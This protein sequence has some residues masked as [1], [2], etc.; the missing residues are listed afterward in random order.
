MA[1][2]RMNMPRAG[3]EPYSKSRSGYARNLSETLRNPAK[4]CQIRANPDI[5]ITNYRYV[6]LYP[7]SSSVV[8]GQSRRLATQTCECAFD[9]RDLF[10]RTWRHR[11]AGQTPVAAFDLH[12]GLNVRR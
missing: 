4:P 11:A 7:S 3:R 5:S 2:N 10:R 6:S 1:S 12:G 9:F 8:S